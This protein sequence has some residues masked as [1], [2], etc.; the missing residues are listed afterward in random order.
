[1]LNR[2]QIVKQLIKAKKAKN[3]LEIGVNTGA[4]FLRIRAPRKMAVDPSFKMSVGRKLKYFIKNPGNINNH[5]YEVPSDDFFASNRAMLEENKPD[6][7]L[8]DGLHT[9]E[10][11]LRDIVNSIEASNEGGVVVVH[12]CNPLTEAAGW[13]AESI[14]HIKSQDI[15]GYTN[16]WNGDVWKAIVYLRSQRPDLEVF[17]LDCDHGVGIVTKKSMGEGLDF[18]KEQVDQLTYKDFEKNRIRF[19]NLKPASY[20]DTFLQQVKAL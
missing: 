4:C 6:V 2:V 12:D 13:P 8:V 14:N 15:P 3:Y 11:S 19:L 16:V 10:Q 5:Y 9:Y 1:M 20:F 7:T 18:T 17:V